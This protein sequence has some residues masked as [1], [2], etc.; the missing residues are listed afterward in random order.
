[1]DLY[2]RNG[3]KSIHYHNTALFFE[4]VIECRGGTISAGARYD[5]HEKFDAAFSPRLAWTKVFERL[6]LKAIYSES[7]R[8]PGID[9]LTIGPNLKP[10]RTAV[11]EFETGYKFGDSFFLSANIFRI[12]EDPIVYYTVNAVES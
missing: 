1:M 10:E 2:F 5:R 3:K 6:H 12:I 4:S 8:A 7:F 11:T 9:N